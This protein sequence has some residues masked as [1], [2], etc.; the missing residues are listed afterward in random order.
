MQKTWG[1]QKVEQK[2]EFD[3][4]KLWKASVFFII[5]T[6]CFSFFSFTND[7]VY[8][9]KTTLINKL[10]KFSQLSFLDK[11]NIPSQLANFVLAY[12]KWENILSDKYK[13]VFL[14]TEN[15]LWDLV[16]ILWYGRAKEQL[17]SIYRQFQPYRKDIFNL[18]WKNGEKRYLVIFE[19]I[20][21]ERPDGG[22]FGSF[23]E[24]S[25]SGG[26]LKDLQIL[27]SYKVIFDQCK[28]TG[29]NWYKD[30]DRNKL[31]IKHNLKKYNK[32]FTYTSFLNSN[33]FGFTDLNW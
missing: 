21:E 20:G 10:A 11:N 2:K 14:F 30:C 24:L 4:F 29:A 17:V 16:S 28:L 31:H 7:M 32:L 18:L 23:A 3:I 27:D 15:H 33:Y 1:F 9:E 25:I 22:F 8:A 12:K 5:F 19:N 26:H 6:I 13:P